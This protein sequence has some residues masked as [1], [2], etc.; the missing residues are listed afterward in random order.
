MAK[1]KGAS[2]A[3]SEPEPTRYTAAELQANALSAFGVQPEVVAGAIRLAGNPPAMT[4]A[5]AE[6]AID[7][8]LRRRV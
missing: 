7:Q 6:A 3:R 1:E 4:K 2:G 8:F 5:E